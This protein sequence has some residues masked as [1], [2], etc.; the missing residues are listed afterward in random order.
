VKD[1]YT[2]WLTLMLYARKLT[3]DAFPAAAEFRKSLEPYLDVD[4]LYEETG[5]DMNKLVQY[6][7]FILSDFSEQTFFHNYTTRINIKNKLGIFICLDIY[8]HTPEKEYVEIDGMN[9][10][11]IRIGWG[12]AV[13]EPHI[14]YAFVDGTLLNDYTS[15]SGKRFPVY[16]QNHALQRL[17]ERMDIPF[18]GMLH[19][20]LINSLLS[21]VICKGSDGA[22]LIEYRH[23]GYK[24]GYLRA[25]IH[26][27]I[28]LI[29]TFLF[30]TNNGTPE[31]EKLHANT[32]LKKEDKIF[33]AIDKLSAFI[34]SDIPKN[35]VIK[36]IFVEAGC[37]SLFMID[38]GLVHISDEMK[39]KPMAMRI[40]HY[41]GLEMDE[42]FIRD[43]EDIE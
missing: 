29:H 39:D 7:T 40:A 15:E 43:V 34:A 4:K 27:D 38:P 31:G 28:L 33:L 8:S 22:M 13:P 19:F 25:E 2:I 32:G 26:E 10:P 21:P 1:F 6:L 16:I 5:S 23:Q 24:T 36:N 3:S 11:M 20:S 12:N 35:E 9:R 14:V 41:L 37:E 18:G 30:L 42:E 17:H